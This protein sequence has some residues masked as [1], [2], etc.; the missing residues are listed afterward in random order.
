M[1]PNCNIFDFRDHSSPEFKKIYNIIDKELFDWIL[2]ASTFG[3]DHGDIYEFTAAL[4]GY[5]LKAIVESGANY[6]QYSKLFKNEPKYESMTPRMFLKACDFCKKN[7]L[8]DSYSEYSIHKTMVPILK[9]LAK[10]GFHGILTREY[11]FNDETMP[12]IKVTTDYA[13]GIFDKAGLD[14]ISLVPM[15]Y[16]WLKKINPSY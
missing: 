4:H 3:Y 5:L 8:I 9:G 10:Q 13:V 11:D 14:M 7:N 16:E 1:R 6:L 12:G 15:R 2:Q